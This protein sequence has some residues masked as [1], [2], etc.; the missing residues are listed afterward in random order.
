MAERDRC[1]TRQRRHAVTTGLLALSMAA[2]ATVGTARSAAARTEAVLSRSSGVTAVAFSPDGTVLAS[3][4]ADGAVRLWDVATGQVHGPVLLAG[5]GAAGAVNAVAF[6]PDGTLLAGGYGDG[7]V[8]LWN[9]ATGQPSGSSLL[10]GSAVNAV[11]FS[12]DGTLLASADA[13]G[14]VQVW[15]PATG[16][17]SGSSLQAGSAVNAVAFSRDG[18]LA[19]GGADGVV[20]LWGPVAGQP[21]GRGIQYWI[22]LVA[23]VIALALA[24]LA[25]VITTRDTWPAGQR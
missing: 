25:A 5:S 11:A 22:I 19:S 3:G 24:A 23:A 13:N 21:A 17:P 18:T 20:L 4:Y 12:P 1:R 6:S 8:R 7:M 14:A 15:N 2:L 16:Q 10:A 9:P